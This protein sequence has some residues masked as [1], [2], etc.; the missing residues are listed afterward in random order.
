MELTF[1]VLAIYLTLWAI[2]FHALIPCVGIGLNRL[3][4]VLS[5]RQRANRVV[6]STA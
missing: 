2:V 4:S 6:A 3:A 1:A 5:E